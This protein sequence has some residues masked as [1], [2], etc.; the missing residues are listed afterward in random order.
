M[1]LPKTRPKPALA[2]ISPKPKS[3]ASNETLARATSA[4]L[5]PAFPSMLTF[6]AI[7]TVSSAR[8][9]RTNWKPFRD[10]PPV[11]LRWGLRYL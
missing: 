4:T 7:S 3:P 2:S 1:S 9:P 5:T 11:T 8:E 10:V 6:Q